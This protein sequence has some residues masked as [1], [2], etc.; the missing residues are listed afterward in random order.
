VPLP[1]WQALPGRSGRPPSEALVAR[2]AGVLPPDVRVHAAAPAPPGFDARFSALHRRYAYR[3]DDS[4]AG[5]PPLRRHEVVAVRGP[6]DVA[7]MDA[8]A[9]HL[10]GLRDFAAFCRRREGASTVRALL[11]YAWRRDA[12]GLA[13]ADVVADA[14]C[15]S[16]VRALVGAALA[17][18]QGRRPPE[19]PEQ[20][21]AGAR[22]DPAVAV[23]PARG[24]VLVE[25]SYPPDEDLARRA[26][27]ARSRRAAPR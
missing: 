14:F 11:T 7:A 26:A 12:D 24:L 5:P 2:L 15:H 8:A 9:G 20:V 18:G 21:L 27:A 13:V 25:V 1:A 3:L 16:M 6:L 22:R 4:P 19:W 23:A 10:L 17:V